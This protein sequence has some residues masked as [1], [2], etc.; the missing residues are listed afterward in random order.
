MLKI[1]SDK[2]TIMMLTQPRN[3]HITK[4]IK[5]FDPV[6]LKE[7]SQITQMKILGMYT[8][9]RGRLST[10][11]NMLVGEGYQFLERIKKQK[12]YLPTQ[13]RKLLIE[14]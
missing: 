8:N 3:S 11:I 1:N 6:S 4:F 9:T 7:I 10:Q 12:I 13:S 2:T 14:I 5:L